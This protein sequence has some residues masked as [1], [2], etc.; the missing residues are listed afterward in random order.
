MMLKLYKIY[1][2]EFG[3]LA[4]QIFGRVWNFCCYYGDLVYTFLSGKHKT[5][6]TYGSVAVHIVQVKDQRVRKRAWFDT[7]S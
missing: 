1:L 3:L 5:R 2:D 6:N 4:V 7:N